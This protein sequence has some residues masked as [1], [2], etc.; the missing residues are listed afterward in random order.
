MSSKAHHFLSGPHQAALVI[1]RTLIGWHFL[2]EGYYKLMLPAWSADGK[3]LPP[4]TSAGYL[5]AA[6]CR[7]HNTRPS[8]DRKVVANRP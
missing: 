5:N 3:P 2:Y 4:W 7:G 8:R 6:S 1:L